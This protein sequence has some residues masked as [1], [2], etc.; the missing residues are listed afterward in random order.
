LNSSAKDT[1]SP[2]FG[3]KLSSAFK[4]GWSWIG[5]LFVGLVSIWPLFLLI[6]VLIIFYR[7]M[8]IAKPKQA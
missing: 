1:D 8:K 7:R 4:T 6:F 5:E 2:S 3:T